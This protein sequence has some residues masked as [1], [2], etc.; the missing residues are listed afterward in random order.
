VVSYS[1]TRKSSQ[2]RLTFGKKSRQTVPREHS[3]LQHLTAKSSPLYFAA[4]P[5]SEGVSLVLWRFRL[6]GP[7]RSMT[8]AR[9]GLHGVPI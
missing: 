1:I 4:L 3:E 5:R 6:I 9:E 2:K 7:G 8:A